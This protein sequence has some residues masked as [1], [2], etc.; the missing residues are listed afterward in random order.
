MF[1]EIISGFQFCIRIGRLKSVDNFL[2]V[3]D[4]GFKTVWKEDEPAK[5]VLNKSE[6][7]LVPYSE[8]EKARAD[9]EII[10]C[11]KSSE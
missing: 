11:F 2:F 9:R 5:I 3:L 10:G 1:D 7:F 8:S 6:N 4:K